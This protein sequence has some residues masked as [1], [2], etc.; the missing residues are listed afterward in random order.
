MM[1]I[2]E[3]LVNNALVGLCAP[4]ASLHATTHLGDSRG[5]SSPVTHPTPLVSTHLVRLS[6]TSRGKQTLHLDLTLNWMLCEHAASVMRSLV[7]CRRFL[8]ACYILR[9]GTIIN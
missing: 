2:G 9:V 3:E 7:F 5:Q 1:M 4:A 6:W 8:S